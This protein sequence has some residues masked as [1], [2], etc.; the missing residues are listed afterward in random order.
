MKQPKGTRQADIAKL[1]QIMHYHGIE[2]FK[3]LL[4]QAYFSASDEMEE[5]DLEVS[6]QYRNEA[7]N[8]QNE[9]DV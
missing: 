9:K 5:I 8:I 3:E 4:S 2:E 6:E 1:Q 7:N